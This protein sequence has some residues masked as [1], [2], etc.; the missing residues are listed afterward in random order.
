[1]I[2]PSTSLLRR[3]FTLLEMMIVIM[4]IGILSTYL[5]VSAPAW[6]DKANMTGS[7][8]NMKRIYAT[9]L[10]Y[11]A[12]N[13]GSW[14]REQ[15]QK[16]FLKPWKDG[17]VEKVEQQAKMYFSPSEPFDEIAY[18][19]DLEEDDITIVEWLEDWDAIGPG[20]TSYAGFTT[21]GDRTLRGRLRKNPGSTAIVS[22]AHMIHRS[23]L[24]YLTADGAHHRL[25][26]VDI[27]DETGMSFDD[28]DDI[29]PGPGCEM[30][31]LQTVSND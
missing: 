25:Q 5:V 29:A 17:M 18:G 27:E 8:Q 31:I 10:D 4:I 16:F 21:G 26:R 9:L 23:A 2:R 11:Q 12:N 7:E 28:G 14:P 1:M 13:N 19:F 20:Y 30:E 15:G 22:D 3:G 6:I 24:L